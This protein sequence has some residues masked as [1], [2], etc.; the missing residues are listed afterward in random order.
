MISVIQ[1]GNQYDIN[2]PYDPI[3]IDLVKNVPGRRWNPQE[4]VW[5]IPKDRL[6]FLLSQFKGTVYESSVVVQSN[7]QINV[8]QS[9][10]ETKQFE[11]PDIDISDVNFR[12]ADGFK[13][14]K[15]QLDCMRY[16]KWRIQNGYRSGFILADK[17]GAG[18]AFTLDTK[19][20][21]PTGFKLMKDI[22]VG[23]KVF[24]ELGQTVDVLATYDHENLN[25]YRVTFSDGKQVTCC[26]DHLWTVLN[27]KFEPTTCSLS[28]VLDG[29]WRYQKNR[30]GYDYRTVFIPRCQ[31]VEFE[32][33]EVPLD[34]YVLGALLG[35]GSL[36]SSTV[37]FTTADSEMV[38]RLNELLPEGYHLHSTPSQADID[39]TIVRKITQSNTLKYRNQVRQALQSL[40]LEGTTSH[41]KFVPEIYKYNTPEV[42]LSV[43]QGLIDTD[44]YVNDTNEIVFTTVSER[45][46]DD[47]TFLVESLGQVTKEKYYEV[48]PSVAVHTAPSG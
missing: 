28:Q 16:Y 25:M 42:R 19:I 46:K 12:I 26:E 8:N 20:Y 36:S 13:P 31:P 34:G 23:D 11:I 7:E 40:G 33:Q 17:P 29:S 32:S 45:L 41:T 1:N 18:K 22:Q 24:N 48:T 14:F 21:T 39:Y 15:H 47:M 3:A 35:D 5:S 38:D 43:I 6:G 37:G 30:R 9:L 27:N 4:K 10:D 44:G 2:F